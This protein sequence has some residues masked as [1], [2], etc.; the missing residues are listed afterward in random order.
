MRAILGQSSAP[1]A[2]NAYLL[3]CAPKAIINMKYIFLQ[4]VPWWLNW[5]PKWARISNNNKN[6]M[7]QVHIDLPIP[8]LY[9]YEPLQ[10][11]CSKRLPSIIKKACVM[12]SCNIDSCIYLVQLPYLKYKSF[13]TYSTN[14]CYQLFQKHIGSSVIS[15]KIMFH[16]R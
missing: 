8:S 9:P 15:W 2:P 3:Q 12:T 11:S 1:Q 13:Q 7:K 14:H 5:F 16:R 10:C 4:I 6:N